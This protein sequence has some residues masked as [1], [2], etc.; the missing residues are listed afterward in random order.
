M[1]KKM[2][3][4]LSDDRLMSGSRVP[5][6]YAWLVANEPHPYSTPNDELR[7]SI[8]AKSGTYKRGQVAHMEAAYCGNLFESTIALDVCDEFGLPAPELSP[9]V[10]RSPDGG[11]Q[12]S[13]DAIVELETP[14]KVFATET[15][16][17][18]GENAMDT[19]FVDLIG[20]IPIEVKT[21][22]SPYIGQVPLWR[23]P[24]QLQMQMMAVDAKFGIVATVHRGNLRHY[25]IYRANPFMQQKITEICM[26]FRARVISETFYPPVNVDD[27]SKT[28]LGGNTDPIELHRIH[29]E[30]ER[31]VQLRKES[32]DIADE[33]AALQTKIMQEMQDNEVAIAGEYQVKWPTRHY[34]AQPAK[35]TPAKESRIVRLKTLQIK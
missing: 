1:E 14:I 6:L 7:Q 25:K 20:N 26:D 18:D 31:L 5:V 3:G 16:E 9:S 19:S 17:I 33:I 24:V 34:K 8:S 10:Y 22:E 32:K 27:C 35:V 21:T 13:A 12:C 2:V 15:V 23:G 11:W 28:H 4:K 29:E 30:V